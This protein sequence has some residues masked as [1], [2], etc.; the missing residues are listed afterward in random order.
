M[1]QP[2]MG[3]RSGMGTQGQPTGGGRHRAPLDKVGQVTVALSAVAG[4]L[5]TFAVNVG[6][7]VFSDDKGFL[8]VA[9]LFAVAGVVTAAVW[10]RQRPPQIRLVRYSVR[11]LLGFAL[12]IAIASLFLSRTWAL[13]TA[14]TAAG[15]TLAA[16]V[17]VTSADT[18]FR[19]VASASLI[20]TGVAAVGFGLGWLP[21]GDIWGGIAILVFGL[22]E[23]GFGLG[24]LRGADI[25][26]GIAVIVLGL[27]MVGVGV[28]LLRGG[29]IWGGAF[30]A[31]GLAM[32]GSGVGYL[33]GGDILIGVAVILAGLAIT[34][35]GVPLLR[36][37]DILIGV[38]VV[39]A[40]LSI[41]GAVVG[42]LRD[43]KVLHGMAHLVAGLAIVGGA[44][45]VV[46]DGNILAGVAGAV[47]G[48]AMVGYGGVLLGRAGGWSRMV[49]WL[50]QPVT[51]AP[52]PPADPAAQPLD[53]D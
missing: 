12:T 46:D 9:A 10:L 35:A 2:V 21:V 40:G 22:A 13:P 11:A 45:G 29:D 50:H 7:N 30:V 33:Y 18:A 4:G 19:L 36:G 24:W 44:V 38:A 14:G 8:V 16:A 39:L 5:T 26:C 32:V 53:S 28:E 52:A 17:T 51:P 37:G 49:A 48:L 6:I 31:A 43:G 34:G 42:L 41:I 47:V 1:A 15:L 3:H 25:W 23:V 27:A 20:G